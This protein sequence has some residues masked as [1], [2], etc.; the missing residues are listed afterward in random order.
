MINR[1]KTPGARCIDFD[2]AGVNIT[3]GGNIRLHCM[4]DEEWKRRHVDFF[5]SDR[6]WDCSPVE[7]EEVWKAYQNVE[8]ERNVHVRPLHGY[9]FHDLFPNPDNPFWAWMDVDTFVGNFARYPFNLLAQLS[10]L[11]GPTNDPGVPGETEYIYMP[12]QLT[13][14]NLDNEALAGAWKKFPEMLSPA[15]FIKN[16]GEVAGWREEGYWS[17]SYIRMDTNSPG[18]DLSYG[19][20]PDLHG[21][22]MYDNGVWQ[23]RDSSQVYLISGREIILTSIYYTRTELESLIL[24]ERYEAIDDL[25]S[26]GWT[27]AADNPTESLL[28]SPR[29]SLEARHDVIVEDQVY[30]DCE[31]KRYRQCIAPHPLTASD[32]PILRATLVRL[33]EQQPGHFYRRLDR[34]Q[35]PRGYE[36]KL[37]KH[38][39]WIKRRTWF[40]YPPFDITNDMVFRYNNDFAEVFRMGPTREETIFARY[41]VDKDKNIG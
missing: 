1:L 5:C 33:K 24:T 22:D 27:G 7:Y 34:D 28:Q 9:I 29:I 40:N 23:K 8:D 13:A 21:D 39:L 20:Y 15:H 35:R 18:A 12:G 6:G 10:F 37:I 41:R 32:P 19:V 36:R 30:I 26:I 31:K 4:P 17:F 16:I 14:F 11:T 2:S 3:W 25:G 38:H